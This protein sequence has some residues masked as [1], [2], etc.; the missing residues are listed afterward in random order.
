LH[1]VIHGRQAA[2]DAASEI[3]ETPLSE[4]TR[5]EILKL[6]EEN[7]GPEGLDLSGKDL[8]GIDL[9]SQAI[10]NE[11]AKIQKDTNRQ[12]RWAIA[13]PETGIVCS[14]NLQKIN[15][16]GADL[17]G[18]NL[19]GASLQGAWLRY[20]N[21]QQANLAG[22]FMQ[23]A[24]LQGAQLE[25]AILDGVDLQG[26]YLHLANLREARLLAANLREA[27][28]QEVNLQGAYL[29][30]A[31]LQGANLMYSHLERADLFDVE[32]LEGAYFYGAFL[33]DTRIKSEQLGEGIGEEKAKRYG[34]AREAYLALKNNFAQMG[35]YDETLP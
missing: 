1:N 33:D 20:A 4:Y 10:V 31:Q 34:K 32:S 6:I 17:Q 27:G 35:Y 5:E 28:I 26:A 2:G 23:N 15:L 21:L 16:V 14:A 30:Q 12:P 11:L 29:K 25:R 18:A 22:T 7:G 24:Q 13:S 3:K 9:S 8:S 19:A